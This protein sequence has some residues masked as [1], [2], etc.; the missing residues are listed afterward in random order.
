MNYLLSLPRSGNHWVR[1][2]LEWFSESPSMCLTNDDKPLCLN[3]KNPNPLSHVKINNKPIIHKAHFLKHIVSTNGKLIL[4]L[5]NYKECIIRHKN[6]IKPQDLDEYM[7]LI[8]LYDRWDNEKRLIIYYEELLQQPKKVIE[9][10][11]SFMELKNE[12]LDYFIDNYDTLFNSSV[13]FYNRKETSFSKG[14]DLS[15]HTKNYPNKEEII[16]SDKYMKNNYKEFI[17]YFK[18]YLNE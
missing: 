12:R 14:S 8:K 15:Y 16:M 13:N 18:E 6:R 4:L 10:I 1:F 3:F 9:E 5:R 11:L 2:I 17:E 7:G